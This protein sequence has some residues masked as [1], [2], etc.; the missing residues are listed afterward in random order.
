MNNASNP[1]QVA[2]VSHVRTRRTVDL[3]ERRMFTELVRLPPRHNGLTFTGRPGADELSNHKDRSA[4]PVQCSVG[5][6]LG[7]LPAD[8]DLGPTLGT[9]LRR[10]P[11]IIPASL[12]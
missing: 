1:Q 11:Q 8:D 6:C 12:A 7:R 10:S 3:I 9:T 2:N 5:L 4:G